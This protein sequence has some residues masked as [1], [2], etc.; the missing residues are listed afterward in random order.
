M[1]K[2]EGDLRSLGRCGIFIQSINKC[3]KHLQLFIAGVVNDP[4][5]GHLLQAPADF[6][7]GADLLFAEHPAIVVHNGHKGLHVS[8]TA[9]V[10]NIGALTGTHFQKALTSQFCNAAVDNSTGDTH[11]LAEFPL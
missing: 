9:I 7:N 5:Q 3:S 8:I 6:Q 2:P 4:M 1:V 11:L 10:G